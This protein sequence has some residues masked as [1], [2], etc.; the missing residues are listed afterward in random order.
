VQA[1]EAEDVMLLEMELLAVVQAVVV[2]VQTVEQILPHLDQPILALVE[3]AVVTLFLVLAVAAV[4]VLALSLFAIPI[5]TQLQ[6]QP[7]VHLL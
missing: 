1:V 6:Q 5:L 7:Q 3:A 2:L 4:E